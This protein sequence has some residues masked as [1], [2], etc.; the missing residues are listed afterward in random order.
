MPND[1]STTS[2]STTPA[3]APMLDEPKA[4]SDD[5]PRELAAIRAECDA[6]ADLARALPHHE[7]EKRIQTKRR[8]QQP[9]HGKRTRYERG[10]SF[11]RQAFGNGFLERTD[12]SDY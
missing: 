8:E 12:V 7:R 9:A 10:Q 1:G 6:K 4:V 2:D 5:R 11:L 3:G